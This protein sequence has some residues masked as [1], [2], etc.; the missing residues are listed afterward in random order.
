MASQQDEVGKWQTQTALFT[1]LL[2]SLLHR[3]LQGRHL[4]QTN[5]EGKR[6]VLLNAVDAL[7]ARF[8]RL[9]GSRQ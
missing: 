1:G 3:L 5:M 9:P 4:C 7:H 6:R 2:V 8:P